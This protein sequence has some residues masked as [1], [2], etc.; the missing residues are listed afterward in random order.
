MNWPE[1]D[2]RDVQNILKR[3]VT[4]KKHSMAMAFTKAFI[5]YVTKQNLTTEYFGPLLGDSLI[6]DVRRKC[7]YNAV[8]T[9]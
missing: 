9:R 1:I 6:P 4:T 8:F 5:N 3:N 7:I 2:P